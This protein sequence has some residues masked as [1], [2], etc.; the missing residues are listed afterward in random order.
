LD[1][2]EKKILEETASEIDGKEELVWTTEFIAQDFTSAFDR[3]F[4]FL[5]NTIG[6]MS[7]EK[8]L[9]YLDMVWKANN[10]KGYITELEAT[11]MLKLAKE[12][13]IENELISMVRQ[14]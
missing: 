8:R 10:N 3:A 4:T 7:K 5:N 11:A 13:Q 9:S 2:D 1:E 12:W 14:S 6:K